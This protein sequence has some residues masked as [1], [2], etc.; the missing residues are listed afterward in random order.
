MSITQ[1]KKIKKIAISWLCVAV[2]AS[3]GAVTG[4]VPSVVPA[5]TVS[6]DDS[7]TAEQNIELGKIADYLSG[8]AVCPDGVTVKTPELFDDIIELTISKSG[9][10]KLSGSN[11]INGSYLDVKI[12]IADGADVTLNCDDAYIKNDKGE[13]IEGNNSKPDEI[14]NEYSYQTDGSGHHLYNIVHPFKV[15]DGC[16]LT[17][18]GKLFMDTFSTL[19]SS[20]HNYYAAKFYDSSLANINYGDINYI[21]YHKYTDDEYSFVDVKYCINGALYNLDDY[22][23]DHVCEQVKANAIGDKTF[24]NQY[25]IVN[26]SDE[27]KLADEN[28][29]TC[30]YCG[31][32][33]F[34]ITYDDGT[35]QT[36]AKAWKNLPAKVPA[37]PADPP[38][39]KFAGWYTADDKKY[40]FT[41]PVTEDITLTAKYEERDIE[42]ITIAMPPIKTTYIEGTKFEPN[43]IAVNVTYDDGNFKLVQYGDSNASDFSFSPS[44]LSLGDTKVTVTYKGKSTDQVVFVNEKQVENITL[45]TDPA[46]KTYF[47][48]QPLD[49]TGGEIKVS[50]DNGQKEAIPLT[51]DM[52]SGFDSSTEGTKTLTVTYG[53]KTTTYDIIVKEAQVTSIALITPPTKK[54][55]FT[56]DELDVTG[57]S[58][59]VYFEDN[60]YVNIALSA[61]MISGFDSTAAGTK[62][63]YVN[64]AGKTTNFFV[65]VMEPKLTALELAAVPAKTEYSLGEAL[66]VTGGKLT[67]TYENNTTAT[68]DITPDM[69]SGFDSMTSGTKTL[70]VKYSSQTVTF[71]ITVKNSGGSVTPSQTT[72]PEFVAPVAP[73]VHDKL[74]IKAEVNG[75]TVKLSWNEINK[76]DGY[77]VYQLINGKYVKITETTDTSATFEGL[78]NGETY[79][80]IVRYVKKGRPSTD[81]HSAKATVYINY[82]PVAVA[83]SEKDSVRLGWN[84]VP[85]AEKYAVY[86]YVDGKAVKLCETE[87]LAVRIKNLKPD[88]EYSY[89]IRAYVDGEWTE[90]RKSDIVTINT[91]AE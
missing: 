1:K 85:N 71:D 9:T 74:E 18:K 21:Y 34:T 87:K 2:L 41:A 45:A 51:A 20:W 32:G 49:V 82:K 67:A 64:Y 73:E 56:G 77:E 91:K 66:D 79:K 27:H 11:Y 28:A 78:K 72:Y 16:N 40:D 43:E 90:M 61:G 17:L 83:S 88:T 4:F 65:T 84:A 36:T 48:D 75:S 58:I 76:A 37:D 86:K 5:V 53:G 10:Y 38:C 8:K 44:M 25:T 62:T 26:V 15:N 29:D 22:V 39:M 80:Y 69:V 60:N 7:V 63:L 46:K 24:S 50:Y 47:I 54:E 13:F 55:Y 59:N 19:V 57:G 6:A 52:V 89:I 42:G 68:I 14:Q 30:E 31:H 23:S 81:S 33:T 3:S 70:T 12:I 35:A